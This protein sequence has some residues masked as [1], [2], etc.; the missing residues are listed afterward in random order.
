[1]ATLGVRI[2]K[3]CIGREVSLNLSLRAACM[4]IWAKSLGQVSFLGYK[5]S[6]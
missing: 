6:I 5:D 4:Y 2:E 3:N 1:M